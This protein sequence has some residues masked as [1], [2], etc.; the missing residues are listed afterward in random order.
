M[1]KELSDI[2]NDDIILDIGPKT[3]DLIYSILIKAK[4][5]YGMG[6]QDTL[7]ILILQLG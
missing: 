7:K 5:Y 4:Q 2:Q 6:L 1:I 3:I